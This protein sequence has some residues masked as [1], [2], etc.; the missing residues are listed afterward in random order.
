MRILFVG[1]HFPRPNN[2][3]IG[4][5]AISQL[6]ALQALGHEIQVISPVA[7]IPQTV[8][9]VLKRGSSA[10]CPPSHDWN[11]IQAQYPKWSVYPVGPLKGI[12]RAAPAAFATPGWWQVRQIAEAML[13]DFRP[14]VIFAHHAA[15]GGYIASRLSAKSGVPWFVTDHDYLELESCRTNPLRWR[16]HRS[17][18]RSVTQWFAVSERMR[19]IMSD[20]FPEIPSRTLY[21]GAESISP[22]MRC[23]PR[24]PEYASA[25]LVFSAGYF[26]RRKNVPVTVRAFDAVAAAHPESIFL[27]AGEG[28]TESEVRLVIAGSRHR[29]RIRFLGPLD[30]S[31]IMQHMCWADVFISVGEN[32]PFATVFSEAMM[33]GT[34]IIFG[35]DGGIADKARSGVHGIGVE[36]GDLKS[37]VAALDTLLSD[38]DRRRAMGRAARELAENELTWTANATALARIMAA[39]LD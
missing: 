21:N 12:V 2:P 15:F 11:G 17:V 13:N 3:V 39:A 29:N 9:R 38:D 26:Y 5:W 8:Q 20:L 10:T 23:K 27:L 18:L 36:P 7:R 1:Q 22:E 35:Q 16:H 14:E 25:K 19:L 34:P 30:H 33:A 4:I 24:P 31:A 6:R 37:S 32:E 28:E